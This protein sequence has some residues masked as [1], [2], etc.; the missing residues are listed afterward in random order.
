MNSARTAIFI[1][2]VIGGAF[3]TFAVAQNQAADRVFYSRAFSIS[4]ALAALVAA[5]EWRKNLYAHLSHF[6]Y[7]TS[8]PVNVAVFRIVVALA[9]LFSVGIFGAETSLG[10]PLPSLGHARELSALSPALMIAPEGLDWSLPLARFFLPYLPVAALF[11]QLAAIAGAVGFCSRT[12]M[13]A[14]AILGTLV[15]GIPN[16][17]GKVFHQ[18][19]NLIWFAVILAASDC[20]QRLAIDAWIRKKFCGLDPPRN[21]EWKFGI[22]IHAAWATFALIY[23]FPGILKFH[24]LGLDW[25]FG[26]HLLLRI[27]DQ[28]FFYG[29]VPRF[30]FAP[31]NHKSL[32]AIGAALVLILELG[33]PL[34]I[35]YP[36]PRMAFALGAF[37]FHFFVHAIILYP[38]YQLRACLIVFINWDHHAPESPAPPRWRDQK[39]TLGVSVAVVVAVFIHGI[40]GVVSW[41]FAVYP[42]FSEPRTMVQEYVLIRATD[43]TGAQVDADPALKQLI[44]LLEP[45]R[46]VYRS[47]QWLIRAGRD[48]AAEELRKIWE[49]LK[50]F[51]PELERA[52]KLQLIVIRASTDPAD[53]RKEISREIRLNLNLP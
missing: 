19:Q 3:A 39:I 23:F 41:P 25:V 49:E 30:K 33:F 12:S 15:F 46:W 37:L 29:W 42:S 8:S 52:K 50:K 34:A 26:D 51:S 21:R 43:E 14:V 13:L 1:F 32:M 38:F 11:L 36:K 6:I 10:L 20:G 5:I 31:E 47:Q 22:P 16:Y 9:T 7:G 45:P 40:L 27:R 18:H 44:R 53:D 17:F 35:L 2:L 28:W 48:E 4:A 24:N